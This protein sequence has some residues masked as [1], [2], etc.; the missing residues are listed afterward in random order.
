MDGIIG[1]LVQINLLILVP[2][3]VLLVMLLYK[4]VML[5]HSLSEFLSIARYELSPAIKD[6]RLTASHVE[7]LSAKAVASVE[8]V[9]RGV[10]ATRPVIGK[11]V[12]N[13]RQVSE[14]IRSGLF[15]L[16][17]GLRRSF[18]RGGKESQGDY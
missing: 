6:L 16:L 11:G 10:E 15:A 5:L 18:T 17:G 1:N 8:S 4:L 13:V 9:E 3:G 7:T 14:D 12:E 2:V